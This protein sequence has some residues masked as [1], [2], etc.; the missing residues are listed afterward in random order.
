MQMIH[1]LFHFSSSIPPAFCEHLVSL[2]LDQSSKLHLILT[3]HPL[4]ACACYSG[5][6]C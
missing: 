4:L 2:H 6:K 1:Q 5:E 3:P